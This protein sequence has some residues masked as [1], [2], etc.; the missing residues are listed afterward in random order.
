[1]YN[2]SK[3]F[4]NA[5]Q[6]HNNRQTFLQIVTTYKLSIL[7][8]SGSA[9][10]I[11]RL[12]PI[13]VLCCRIDRALFLSA[14]HRGSKGVTSSDASASSATL[15]L[16]NETFDRDDFSNVTPRIIQKFG[17]RLLSQRRHPLNLLKLRIIDFFNAKH[18][19]RHGNPLFSVFED[20][21]PVVSPKQNFDNLLV[22]ENHVSRLPQDTYYINRNHLLRSH[23]TAHDFEL[24]NMGADAFLIF[25]DVFRRDAIDATHYPVFHQ[26]RR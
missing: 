12:R 16:G 4:V 8:Q 9:M 25:G 20:I 26:V 6:T 13:R 22:P 10:L 1:M 17:R 7:F 5:L 11:A 3:V 21:S 18:I 19:R 2:L 23:T 15:T 14:G 24:I